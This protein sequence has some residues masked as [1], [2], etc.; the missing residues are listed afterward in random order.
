MINPASPITKGPS[1]LL[2]KVATKDLCRLYILDYGVD[3]SRHFSGI[4]QLGY[5]ECK[6]SGVNYFYPF[7]PADERCYN[8][9]SKLPWYYSSDK[10]EYRYISA[11]IC[12][13]SSVLDVGC[14]VGG[15]MAALPNCRFVGLETSS[16][17][18]S[19]GRSKGVPIF[20]ISVKDH[21]LD[22]ADA[23][24]VVTAFQVLEHVTD[25][26]E[27]LRDMVSCARPGGRVVVSVPAEDGALGACVNYTLN[28]PPHHLTRWTDRALT[29]TLKM[30]G[31]T[32]IN[33]Q[34]LPLTGDL[35][36]EVIAQ[37]LARG[38]RGPSFHAKLVRGGPAERAFLSVLRGVAKRL[39][40]GI[41]T[42][43]IAGHT[44]VAVGVKP[45]ASVRYAPNNE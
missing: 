24:D 30:V 34:H 43:C 13:G 23:Y 26:I 28:L 1:F 9:L 36:V 3:V 39:R 12:Q 37:F 41:V 33:L 19:A 16:A 11:K 22:H 2:S 35:E 6:E 20:P 5:Y 7:C 38:L 44:V 31:L 8:H 25:P 29:F 4:D 14:G 17:A 45:P 10:E 21:A 27:F 15:F 40:R 32:E 18:V 42:P